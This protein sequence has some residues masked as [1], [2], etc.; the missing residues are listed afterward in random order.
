QGA[1]RDLHLRRRDRPEEQLRHRLVDPRGAHTLAAGGPFRL[2]G[3]I[4]G[5]RRI[6]LLLRR[7]MLDPHLAAATAAEDDPLHQPGAPAGCPTTFVPEPVRSQ[8]AAV[9]QEPL[10]R[11]IA[12]EG[13]MNPHR[14][15]P[16]PP[17]L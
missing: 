6:S 10:P 7:V 17:A 11:D 2:I 12:G 8:Q 14:P 13:P 3:T 9:F 16:P 5:V 15:V 4:T 1:Q